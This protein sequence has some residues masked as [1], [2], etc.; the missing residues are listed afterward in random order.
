MTQSEEVVERMFLGYSDE[1]LEQNGVSKQQIIK[2]ID[3]TLKDGK[4]EFRFLQADWHIF[5][6][7]G[8][9]EIKIIRGRIN[10]LYNL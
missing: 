3:D 7:D 6:K 9:M 1:Q 2:L 10:P 4:A 5:Q 8:R